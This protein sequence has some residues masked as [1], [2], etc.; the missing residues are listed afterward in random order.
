VGNKK[1]DVELEG[2]GI[3]FLPSFVKI[4]EMVYKLKRGDTETGPSYEP[5]S[6]VLKEQQ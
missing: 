2:N 5:I 6:S 3:I 1:Y 4:F